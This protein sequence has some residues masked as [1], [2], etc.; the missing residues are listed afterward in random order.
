[1][2]PVFEPKTSTGPSLADLMTIE[3]SVSIFYSYARETE[4]SSM[5]DDDAQNI[6]VMA[7]NNKAVIALNR[8]PH[9][10]PKDDD[11]ESM[12]KVSQEFQEEFLSKEHVVKWVGAHIIAAPISLSKKEESYDTLLPSHSMT[13]KNPNDAKSDPSWPDYVIDGEIKIIE[14]KQASNGVFYII[15][16][17]S[18]Y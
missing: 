11:M 1:M 7:P 12:P 17:T 9:Q 15:D 4:F 14:K 2:N 13:F 6:T 8:K 10:G 18:L 5:F 3:R 16:G